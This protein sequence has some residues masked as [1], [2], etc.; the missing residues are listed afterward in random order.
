MNRGWPRRRYGEAIER[1]PRNVE[2]LHN[3]G[4]VL[5]DLGDPNRAIQYLERARGLR[6]RCADQGQSRPRDRGA[7]AAR[8]VRISAMAGRRRPG[9]IGGLRRSGRSAF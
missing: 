8:E 2:A 3:I 6:R 5:I 4:V 1:E 7:A 9:T